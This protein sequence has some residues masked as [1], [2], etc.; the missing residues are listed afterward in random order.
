MLSIF[1]RFFITSD[2]MD[3]KHQPKTTSE[4]TTLTLTSEYKLDS[5]CRNFNS[6][7]ANESTGEINTAIQLSDRHIAL[8]FPLYSK[9]DPYKSKGTSIKIFHPVDRRYVSTIMTENSGLPGGNHQSLQ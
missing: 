1:S 6:W 5:N 9:D 3:Q 4:E 8:I 2:A 7:N